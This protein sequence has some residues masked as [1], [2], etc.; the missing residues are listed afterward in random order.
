M[1][2]ITFVEADGERRVVD[3]ALGQ[4]LMQAALD[5]GVRGVIAE[6]GGS[7]ACGTCHCQLDE[8]WRSAA[9]QASE[10]ERL[11][12][13]YSEHHGPGSRLSCQVPVSGQL[14]GAVVRLPPSQ[15]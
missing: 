4:T 13:A 12:V 5:H 9:G 6:C 1:V 8:P 10:D 7:L 3:A 14:D 15:P 2:R 11:L